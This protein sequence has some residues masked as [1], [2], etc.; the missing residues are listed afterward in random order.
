MIGG[1]KGGGEEGKRR[2]KGREGGRRRDS[3]V[4]KIEG[5]GGYVEEKERCHR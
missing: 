1:T 5:R 2:S 4:G 3:D